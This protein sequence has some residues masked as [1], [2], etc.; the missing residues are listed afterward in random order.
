M[1][2]YLFVTVFVPTVTS[3]YRVVEAADA[4]TAPDPYP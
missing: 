4:I 3:A 1:D 2:A